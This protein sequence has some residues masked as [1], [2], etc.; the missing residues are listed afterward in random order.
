MKNLAQNSP[1]CFRVRAII[2]ED[3]SAFSPDLCVETRSTKKD[4]RAPRLTVEADGN[5]AV[6]VTWKDRNRT[7]GG[8]E[9]LY[10]EEGA[11]AGLTYF[12]SETTGRQGQTR[13]VDRGL[14]PG[15]HCY[16]VQP[17]FE[18]GRPAGKERAQTCVSL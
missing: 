14:E 4:L 9:V 11:W 17:Y 5:D 6:A 10:L 3:Y 8:Y 13:F 15:T 1:Y 7:E 16:R 18:P 2:G 12:E